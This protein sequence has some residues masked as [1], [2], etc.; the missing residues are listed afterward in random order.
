MMIP[1][2]FE[3]VAAE[4]AGGPVMA[5]RQ[6]KKQPKQQPEQQQ[7][8]HEAQ[9]PGLPPDLDALIG[10]PALPCRRAKGSKKGG[11]G[12]K[13]STGGGKETVLGAVAEPLAVISWFDVR[14]IYVRVSACPSDDEGFPETL[15]FRCPSRDI[16][17]ELEVNGAR[18][19]PSELVTLS[20]RRDRVD[21]NAAEATYVSTD[22]LRA[23]SSFEFE[24]A[25]EGDQ[26]LCGTVTR[27]EHPEDSTGGGEQEDSSGRGQGG[28]VAGQVAGPVRTG[29]NLDC[30]CTLGSGGC[31]FL[32]NKQ[33]D[34]SALLVPPSMEVCLVGRFNGLPVMLTDTVALTARR[35]NVRVVALD[36]IPEADEADRAAAEKRM[37]EGEGQK[38]VLRESPVG[39]CGTDIGRPRGMGK[40][41]SA[42]AYENMYDVQLRDLG[43]YG[44]GAYAEAEEAEMSWFNAGVRV[45]VGLGLGMC[46]GIGIG[47]GIIVRSYQATT[48]SFR[49]GIF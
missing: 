6:L 32:R 2:S 24:V 5:T 22:R 7:W 30:L 38:E 43:G 35:R 18:I 47:V 4:A 48:R 37:V 45:G 39:G 13:G 28:Q 25:D 21:C 40:D 8:T 1:K 44:V 12:T 3:E 49:R 29:W 10:L 36:A 33:H 15:E 41:A 26:L 14:L 19:A 9:P 23:S 34:F 46:L 27:Q 16:G 20:L 11:K 17:C 31:V 42:A